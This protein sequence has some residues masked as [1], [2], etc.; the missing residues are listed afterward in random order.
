MAR[1][2]PGSQLFRRCRKAFRFGPLA[3]GDESN[4]LLLRKLSAHDP[5]F[6]GIWGR[7]GFPETGGKRMAGPTGV[8]VG[9]HVVRRSGGGG[10]LR[11]VEA[12]ICVVGAG[13]AGV[14]A[15]IE[16]ARLGRRVVLI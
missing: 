16:A 2:R 10:T 8:S 13:I 5:A 9:T 6:S 14:S 3:A 4:F 7:L 15:A 12:D 11:R 1:K